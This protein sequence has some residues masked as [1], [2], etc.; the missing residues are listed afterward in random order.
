VHQDL[1][2]EAVV[3]AAPCAGAL[4]RDGVYE[5]INI[6]IIKAVQAE[7]RESGRKIRVWVMMSQ[8]V[9]EHPARRGVYLRRL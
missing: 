7:Q 8:A 3:I 5:Q 4:F 2:V 6:N 1:P 9:M